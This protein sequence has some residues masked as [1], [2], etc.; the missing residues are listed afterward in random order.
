MA[1][2]APPPTAR[3]PKRSLT[4]SPPKSSWTPWGQKC[5][6]TVRPK[7]AHRK[8]NCDDDFF[9]LSNVESVHWNLL[10][11]HTPT[12]LCTDA[13]TTTTIINRGGGASSGRRR[14]SRSSEAAKFQIPGPPCDCGITRAPESFYPLLL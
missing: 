9:H 8:T 7:N 2:L 13:T 12:F 1:H 6:G 5:G 3:F 10:A 14:R 11:K 4:R